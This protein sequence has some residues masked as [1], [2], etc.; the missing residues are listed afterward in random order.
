MSNAQKPAQP[1]LSKPGAASADASKAEAP[2]A[3]PPP[4]QKTPEELL[5]ALPIPSQQGLRRF[6]KAGANVL[7]EIRLAASS[8][9]IRSGGGWAQG[10]SSTKEFETDADAAREAEKLIAAKLAEGYAEV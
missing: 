1:S 8:L 9:S 5:K 10:S 7:W 6:H 4:V 3:L 2:D